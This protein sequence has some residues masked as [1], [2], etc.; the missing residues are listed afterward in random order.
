L[1]RCCCSCQHCHTQQ[2]TRGMIACKCLMLQ[3]QLFCCCKGALCG[4]NAHKLTT[5]M[6]EWRMRFFVVETLDRLLRGCACGGAVLAQ[7][8]MSAHTNLSFLRFIFGMGS[9]VR[10]ILMCS[11]WRGAP[12]RMTN[13][14][15]FHFFA[16]LSPMSF[17]KLTKR[18]LS[19]FVSK[20]FFVFF[21][22]VCLHRD[23]MPPM[24]TKHC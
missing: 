24:E 8:C 9:L 17:F 19:P 15:D 14:V 2:P 20:C 3:Q 11:L 23:K 16:F 22:S 5:I 12:C 21:V 1:L 7:N 4:M 13:V 10:T 18:V 6:V